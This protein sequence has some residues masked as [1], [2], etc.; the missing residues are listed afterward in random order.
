MTRCRSQ[1]TDVRSSGY[2]L[3]CRVCEM[4]T[5]P[6]APR[7]P[8]LQYADGVTQIGCAG[9]SGTLTCRFLIFAPTRLRKLLQQHQS[10]AQLNNNNSNGSEYVPATRATA[11]RMNRRHLVGIYLNLWKDAIRTAARRSESPFECTGLDLLSAT[12]PNILLH[13]PLLRG[14]CIHVVTARY[15]LI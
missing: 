12:P 13:Q 14:I 1:T 11:R 6:V 10:R 7:H 8:V 3:G 4:G 2:V 9:T 15:L 5:A